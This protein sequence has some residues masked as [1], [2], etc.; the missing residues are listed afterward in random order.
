MQRRG[1]NVLRRTRV[2]FA[3]AIGLGFA[4]FTPAANAQEFVVKPIAEKKVK[5]LPPGPLFW[6]VETFP[7]LEQ[8]QAAAGSFALAAPAAGRFWL[9]TLGPSGAATPGGSK[10]AEIGPVA[11]LTAPEYLLRINNA[12]GPPGSKT[13]VHTHPGSES[14]YVLA[15]KLSQTT[16]AGEHHVEAGAIMNG[17]GA[18]VP[19]EV[20]SSG[21]VAL[22]AL[23]MFVVDATKPFSSHASIR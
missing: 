1:I 18:D 3:I 12:G 6:R 9:F 10:V 2:M 11:P 7:S 21:A 16:P 8:A 14:F 4:A 15:G 17:H 19:M 5:E 13:P 22:N 23:V 20:R